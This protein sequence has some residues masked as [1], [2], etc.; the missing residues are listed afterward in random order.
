MSISAF[1]MHIEVHRET[2]IASGPVADDFLKFQEAIQRPGIKKVVFVNSP[3]GDL[4][5]GLQV[6]R[7][8]RERGL[9]TVVSGYCVSACSIMFM[10]GINRSFSDVF[11]SSMTYVGIHGAS[12]KF[13]NAVLN[14]VQPEIFAFY[15]LTMGDKFNPTVMNQA[16]YDM[17]DA[18]AMLTVFES[19]REPQRTPYHCKASQMARRNCTEFKDLDALS[20]GV[21]TTHSLTRVQLPVAYAVAPKVLGQDLA[22][23]LD[24]P[25]A[26][27]EHLSNQQCLTDFCRNRVADYLNNQVYLEHKALAIAVDSKGVGIA[28]HRD[29]AVKAFLSAIYMCNHN[30]ETPVQLCETH[31]TDGYDVRGY[32]VDGAASHAQALARLTV[33]SANDYANESY[34]GMFVSARQLRT[35]QVHDIT[36]QTLDGIKTF[37]TQELARALK[38]DQPPVLIDVWAGAN[39]AIPGALTLLYGG[40]AFDDAREEAA[41]EKR[42]AGLLRLLSPDLAKPVVFY[43]MGRNC[44]LSVNAAMRAKKLG[45]AQVGWYRGGMESWKAANL[46]VARVVIR[47]VAN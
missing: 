6:G 10:G 3:G 9:D 31:N 28:G 17:D 46:P 5:T 41:Y 23:V 43:C 29:T 42:F 15:K 30:H 16:L 19:T 18:G 1:G 34:G 39:E 8:I 36:P 13:T 4:W 12:N 21:V 38:S 14:F 37:T 25:A 7:L 24:D 22:V 45:Y 20:L 2:V 35:Q 44:W 32:Y 40:I 47:A 33:P 26:Y 27:F 11:S